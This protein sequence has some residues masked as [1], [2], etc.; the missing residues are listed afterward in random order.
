MIADPLWSSVMLLCGLL[1]VLCGPLRSFVGPL[2]YL[3]IPL[4]R[5][6]TVTLEQ[7]IQYL[8]IYLVALSIINNIKC[9]LVIFLPRN[10]NFQPI[11]SKNSQHAT[12]F[13]GFAP[14]T[15]AASIENIVT[16]NEY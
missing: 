7:L 5:A 1:W 11:Y 15:S 9:C 8:A 16:R 14:S 10:N 3:V 4:K 6:L 13:C 12:P 2:R